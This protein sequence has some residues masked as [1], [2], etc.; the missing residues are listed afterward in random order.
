MKLVAEHFRVTKY[1]KL[2]MADPVDSSTGSHKKIE[3]I[4]DCGNKTIVQVCLVINGNTN[5][6]GK[7]NFMS[8][9]YWKNTKFGKLRMKDSIDCY[10][11]SRVPVLWICDCSRE[12]LIKL[13]D[14]F[15][16][17]I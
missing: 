10:S 16:G 9:D 5:S 12:S 2:I 8:A 11:G 15:R 14:V 17:H 3:W 13:Y 1:G 4:C 6:C 7:C